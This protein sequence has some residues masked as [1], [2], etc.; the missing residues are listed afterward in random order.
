M[1]RKKWVMPK[2][3]EP[4]REWFTNTGGN[5]IEDLMSDHLSAHPSTLF[6]NGPRA[7]LCIAC[8]AQVHL[9]EN[10]RP[11]LHAQVAYLKR[12]KHRAKVRGGPDVSAM[13]IADEAI[14]ALTK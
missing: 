10:M 8:I 13:G 14:A 9:L 2:W 12:L 11:R 1:K 6:N 5:S 4:Y 3:M 7:A